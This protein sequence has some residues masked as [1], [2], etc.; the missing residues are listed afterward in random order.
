MK[1]EDGALR[2]HA[3]RGR[4]LSQLCPALWSLQSRQR[5]VSASQASACPL[6]AQRRQAGNP[7]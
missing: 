5:P 3:R 7:Q 6:Q 2:G 4:Y 1:A